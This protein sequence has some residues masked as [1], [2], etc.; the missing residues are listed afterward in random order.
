[1]ERHDIAF[2]WY[3]AFFL[4]TMAVIIESLGEKFPTPASLLLP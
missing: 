2:Y 3:A 4:L 1:M